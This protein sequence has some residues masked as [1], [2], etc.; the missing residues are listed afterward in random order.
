MLEK[1]KIEIAGKGLAQVVAHVAFMIWEKDDFRE[2]IDF[3]NISKTEQD[4]IFNELEVTFLGLFYL[5]LENLSSQLESQEEQK[6]I[7]DLKPAL[8]LGF[9]GI[10]K[11][12]HLEPNLIKNW[13]A[14]IEIRFKEYKEDFELLLKEGKKVRKFKKDPL[15][16]LGWA[17]VETITLDCLSHLRRGKLDEKD[18]LQKYLQE[19]VINVDKIYSEAIKKMLFQPV[20]VS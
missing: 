8:L 17:R 15:M 6:L 19:W 1:E 9:V 4:R 7:D 20:A 11:E 16:I 18:P 13:E 2:L 14:L 12:M 3:D 10:F 5:Y